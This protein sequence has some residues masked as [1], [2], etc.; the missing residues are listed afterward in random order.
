MEGGS[1]FAPWLSPSSCVGCR[2]DSG[3]P[4]SLLL[5]VRI[6][7]E[8]QNG[9]SET[10]M[11]LRISVRASNGHLWTHF[12]GEDKSPTICKPLLLATKFGGTSL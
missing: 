1:P 11:T 3:S 9:R 10:Q 7:A 4:S 8:A 6:E 5:T 2:C 12:R